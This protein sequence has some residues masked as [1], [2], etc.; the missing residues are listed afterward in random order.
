MR[1]RP[2]FRKL[3]RGRECMVRIPAVCNHDPSTTVL[4]HVGGAGIA[5]KA[6]DLAGAWCCSACHDVIDGRVTTPV[7]RDMVK[8]WHLEGVVRTLEALEREGVL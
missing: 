3:A 4:A 2:D 7:T 8:L 5:R 6:S 1:R